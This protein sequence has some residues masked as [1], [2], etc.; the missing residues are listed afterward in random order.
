MNTLSDPTIVI[1][2]KNEAKNE[3]RLIPN[4]PISAMRWDLSKMANTRV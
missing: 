4:R 2:A 3:A 1:P